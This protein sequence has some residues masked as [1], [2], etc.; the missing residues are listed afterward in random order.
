MKFKEHLNEKVITIFHGD[1][2]K[3]SKIDIKLMNNGNNQEGIGIY[4]G[5]LK[6]ANAYG[7]DIVSA[8]I[9]D[10]FFFPSRDLIGKHVSKEKIFKILKLLHDK[11]K[12]PLYYYITDFGVELS[13]P[14]D[15]NDDH[16]RD[17]AA[18]LSNDEC[19]NFQIDLAER[20]GVEPFVK[21]WNKILPKN[22]GLF[23]KE[24]GFY[25]IIN[26]KVKLKQVK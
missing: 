7:R 6:T 17:L 4:F 11:D 16:L 12:E 14:E 26:N 25:A 20:F 13:V 8:E 3:T 18:K 10:K 2:Y 23:N 22:L 1:N 24:L 15:V 19:R 9:D 21:A 5:D